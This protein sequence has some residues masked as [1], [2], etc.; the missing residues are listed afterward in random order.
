MNN[1]VLKNNTNLDTGVCENF[2]LLPINDILTELNIAFLSIALTEAIRNQERAKSVELW[3]K[4]KHA[5]ADRSP[6]QVARMEGKF[7][8]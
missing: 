7:H 2:A 4:L 3:F 5:I 8:G 1:L 6:S